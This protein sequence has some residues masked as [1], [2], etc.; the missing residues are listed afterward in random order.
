MVLSAELKWYSG[1]ALTSRASDY[2]AIVDAFRATSMVSV[3]L[4]LGVRRIIPVAGVDEALKMKEEN[5]D[6]ILVGEERGIMPPGFSYGNS[7]SQLYSAASGG[8]LKGATVVHRSSAGT[9]SISAALKSKREG[10]KYTIVTS[11]M[12]DASSV[13]SYIMRRN[14]GRDER[15]TVVCSGYVDKLYA[16]EDEIAA[17]A[18]LSSLKEIDPSLKMNEVATSAYLAYRGVNGENLPKLLRGTRSGAKII[19]VGQESDIDFCS[20]FNIFDDVVGVADGVAISN[21]LS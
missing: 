11:S 6:F 10:A 13:A 2:L 3:M 4:H 12:L 19:E 9:Q 17:G 8:L 7:P 20:R 15:L 5:S 16:L 1:S 14:G 18:L 21:A